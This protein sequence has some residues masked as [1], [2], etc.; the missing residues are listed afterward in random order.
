MEQKIKRITKTLN[1]TV[2]L[3]SINP[4]WHKH[5]IAMAKREGVSLDDLAGVHCIEITKIYASGR[6]PE[7][8]LSED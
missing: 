5:V 6:H 1:E 7:L 8:F 3:K 4:V 2:M